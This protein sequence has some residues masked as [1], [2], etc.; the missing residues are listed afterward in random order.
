MSPTK[1]F[2]IFME[3]WFRQFHW[4]SQLGILTA[5]DG[6]IS[7]ISRKFNQVRKLFIKNTKNLHFNQIFKILDLFGQNCTAANLM[8]NYM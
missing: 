7:V 8:E 5:Y 1:R 2:T 6:R 4:S 3:L